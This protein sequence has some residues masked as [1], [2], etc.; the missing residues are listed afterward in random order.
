M[1]RTNDVEVLGS[2]AMASTFGII[3]TSDKATASFSKYACPV[4]SG[5]KNCKTTLFSIE[6]I[7]LTGIFLRTVW[8]F[9]DH[10]F[11]LTS[12]V[13]TLPFSKGFMP[14]IIH[15]HSKHRGDVRKT[16]ILVKLA[17]HQ[18]KATR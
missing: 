14:F 2:M 13:Y 1:L 4:S 6:A 8:F 16:F 9:L 7:L 10:F 3:I 15:F 18:C 12:L 11:N 5:S 17:P